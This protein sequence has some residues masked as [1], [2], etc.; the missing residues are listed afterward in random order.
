MNY[1]ESTMIVR[2]LLILAAT[3]LLAMPAWA[4]IDQ[5]VDEGNGFIL[6]TVRCAADNIHPC[7]CAIISGSIE[8]DLEHAF[9]CWKIDGDKII[10]ENEWHRFVKRLDEIKSRINNPS[11]S[12][13][14]LP[15]HPTSSGQ[16]SGRIS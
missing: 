2:R 9:V 4:D 13:S 11:P 16:L 5:Y 6:L 14:P 7:N 10:F 3:A 1:A 15:E 12:T 8:P